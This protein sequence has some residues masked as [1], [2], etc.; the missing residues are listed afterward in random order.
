MITEERIQ[1]LERHVAERKLKF[2]LRDYDLLFE[3]IVAA[4]E[5]LRIQTDHAKLIAITELVTGWRK[6]LEV[7]R[8]PFDVE[9][10]QGEG[11]DAGDIM[12]FVIAELDKILTLKL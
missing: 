3:A 10:D 4:R 12:R 9:P 11:C 2:S 8:M 6:A 7:G 5:L 1:E